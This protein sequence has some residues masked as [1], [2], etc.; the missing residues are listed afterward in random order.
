MKTTTTALVN[1]IIA[2]IGAIVMAD[3]KQKIIHNDDI[4]YDV[5]MRAAT[6]YKKD[7]DEFAK[8]LIESTES[9]KKN[10]KKKA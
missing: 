5:R 7:A 4:P 10:K 3:E 6:S 9:Y 8:L 1:M 2:G